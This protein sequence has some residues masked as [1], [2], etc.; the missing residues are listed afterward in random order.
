MN[1]TLEELAKQADGWDPKTVIAGSHKKLGWQCKHGHKW[2][3]SV[4]KRARGNGCHQ[5]S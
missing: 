3:A 4:G 5:R 1:T 2:S